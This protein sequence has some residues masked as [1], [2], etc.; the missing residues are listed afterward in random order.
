MYGCEGKLQIESKTKKYAC[1]I[2]QSMHSCN[3]LQEQ[4][5]FTFLLAVREKLFGNNFCPDLKFFG[6]KKPY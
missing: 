3:L 4:K 2:L 5:T 1:S 6:G